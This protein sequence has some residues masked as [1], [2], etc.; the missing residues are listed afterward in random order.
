[1]VLMVDRVCKN[2]N[3]Q[4][5]IA[6]TRLKE[7]R[8]LFCSRLCANKYNAKYYLVT[9]KRRKKLSDI[10]KQKAFWKGKLLPQLVK[11][12][13]SISAK[14]RYSR[15]AN[16]F[17]TGNRHW[18]WKGGISTPKDKRINDPLWK[19][20]RKKVYKRDNWICQICGKH[21]D[22]DIQC[23]HILPAILG[24]A[25]NPSNL[26]TLCAKCHRKADYQF[27]FLL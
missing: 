19:D 15:M 12:K 5:S 1:M 11:E 25:D 7:G 23:H 6:K 14:N 17:Q 10:M 27:Q 21:C 20:I 22:K 13:M 16:G 2:C 18:N 24:G 26:K 8:G 3:K 4:F 9:D